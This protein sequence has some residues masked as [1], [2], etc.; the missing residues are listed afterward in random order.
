MAIFGLG[1]VF[2]VLSRSSSYEDGAL[3]PVIAK[4]KGGDLKRFDLDSS[5]RRHYDAAIPTGSREGGDGSK[6]ARSTARLLPRF[7]RSA[8]RVRRLKLTIS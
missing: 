3:N 7:N 5:L 4:W 8:T 1:P 6:G 2:D